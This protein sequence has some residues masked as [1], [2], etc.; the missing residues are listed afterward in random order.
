MTLAPIAATAEEGQPGRP[1]PQRVVT[2]GVVR[3]GTAPDGDIGGP[4][5]QELLLH[6]PQGTTARF[7][8]D[9]SFNARWDL[10]RVPIALRNA[11]DD[12]ETDI[13]LLIGSLATV[14]AARPE[15][16]LGKPVVS[17]FVQRADAFR[18]PHTEGDRS[19]KENLSFMVLPQRAERDIRTFRELVPFG[20]LL[21]AANPNDLEMI[22][23]IGEIFAAYEKKLGIGMQLEPLTSDIDG[24]LSRMDESVEAV[25]IARAPRLS[26][27]QRT[28][29]IEGLA[30]RKI[31]T[32]SLLGHPDVDLGALSAVTPDITEQVVRRV[33]L[34]LSR[35]IRGDPVSELPVLL[36]VDT[37]LL[38]NGRTAAAIGYSPDRETRL[39]A[40][41]LHGEALA[42]TAEPLSLAGALRMAE[43]GNT[44]L[45]VKD[46][47]VESIRQ[48]QY[49]GRSGLL[50]QLQADVD[51]TAI[52]ADLSPQFRGVIAEDSLLGKLTLTQML[53]DDD[54]VSD[55]RSSVRVFEGSER[56]REAE[57]LDVLRAAGEAFLNLAL[58]QA[59]Y[60]I[61]ADNLRLSEDF[62]ELA[63]LRRDVGYSGRAEILRWESVV[64]DRR[65][66]LFR[67]LEKIQAA[68]IS[69]NQI[70]G[71]EQD[72]RWIPEEIEVDPN[73]F[74]LLGGR[75]DPILDD[76]ASLKRLRGVLVDLA[77]E[78]GA[79]IQALEKAIEAQDINLGRMKRR[80]VLP[81]FFANLTYAVDLGGSGDGLPTTDD[82]FYMFMLGASYPVFEGGLRRADVRK[83]TSDMQA[84]ERWKK[85]VEERVEQATRTAL[86]MSEASFSRIRFEQQAAESAGENLSLVR[87]QYAEGLVNVTD[88]LSAQNQKFA[89]EQMAA[90]AVYEY[91]ANLVRLQRAISWFEDD[92]TPEE[93]DRFVERIRAAVAAE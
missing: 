70:L 92:K 68:R 74:Y 3:D 59:L 55:Y 84:L 38:I 5:E 42:E 25:Y 62:L 19:I 34:N 76:F 16:A 14:E 54:V 45:T 31:P 7:K 13:V 43:A 28:R 64:A 4:I 72:R 71:A 23:E 20:T 27:A 49:R 91:L 35:L 52:D 9:P 1:S 12:P 18:L 8:S 85:L 22:G 56:D 46:A 47:E 30:E 33:A 44:A 89:A 15:L 61:E 93:R 10:L 81:S 50:P 29:L 58:A 78:S 51:Y 75:L 2:I 86:D 77:L 32:F 82:D 6:L 67:S 66:A 41:F 57:R 65:S 17:C 48:D 11:L 88:L 39:F 26:R 83:A 21:V 69:L 36:S 53:Y 80:Y 73:V 63:N 40:S 79:E 37:R 90:A 60:R 87:D 24:F